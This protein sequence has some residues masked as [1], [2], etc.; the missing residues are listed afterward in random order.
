[1]YTVF[2][3]LPERQHVVYR[4]TVGGYSV[5]RKKP[6]EWI[7]VFIVDPVFASEE[8]LDCNRECLNL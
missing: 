4:S 7:E 5:T 2:G 6:D 1:M 8:V 3:S